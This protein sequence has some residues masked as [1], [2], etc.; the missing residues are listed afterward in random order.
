MTDQQQQ[1]QFVNIPLQQWIQKEAD[2]VGGGVGEATVAAIG[3]IVDQQQQNNNNN[4]SL[5]Q[6]KQSLLRKTTV[7]YGIAKLLSRIKKEVGYNQQQS[8]DGGVAIID[9]TSTTS[10]EES[11]EHQCINISNFLVQI[12]HS[13]SKVGDA[14]QTSQ[15]SSSTIDWKDDVRGVYMT[16]PIALYAEISEPSFLLDNF[17]ND[18]DHDDEIDNDH[19]V[20]INGD[21]I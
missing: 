4:T 16:Q 18:H 17:D 8:S 15:T 5:L 6:R 21:D 1:Q 9:S 13:N 20:V 7:A 2:R 19:V 11:S 3:G 10:P 12:P 14:P